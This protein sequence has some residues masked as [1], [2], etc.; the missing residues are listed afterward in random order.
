MTELF[1]QAL[2]QFFATIDPLGMAPIFLG[3]T[4]GLSDAERRSAALRAPLIAGLIL[5]FFLLVGR[6]TLNYLG[7]GLPAFQI[8]GGAL[9]FLVAME[10][11]FEKRA[12]RRQAGAEA[13]QAEV[14]DVAV[15]PLAAPLIAGPAAITATLL[16]EA[17][18]QDVGERAVVVGAL[19]VVVAATALV[20]SIAARAQK[21]I[22]RS[23]TNVF[24]RVLGVLLAALAAQ[25]IVNGVTAL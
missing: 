22:P 2:A 10:M 23:V 24:T 7:V 5:L 19:C 21:V 12:P 25:I 18:A 8:S 14:A 11:V 1:I 4:A 3:V 16:L 6:P 13:A 15:F 9:L 17:G 20:L